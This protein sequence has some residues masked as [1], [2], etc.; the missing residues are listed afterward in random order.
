MIVQILRCG[1]NWWAKHS[2]DPSDPLCF[3]RNSAYFNSTGLMFGRRLRHLFLY[4]GRIRF[5]RTSG[6]DPEFVER[7]SGKT[8]HSPGPVSYNGSKSLLFDLPAKGQQPDA[9]LATLNERD[10]GAIDF[11]DKSWRSTGVDV[12]A[13]SRF[14][15]RYEAML[16][17]RTNAWVCTSLGFWQVSSNS[18]QLTISEAES[19]DTE[20]G[21]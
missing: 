12:I 11:Q 5:N 19:C 16:L 1:V 21:M 2:K 18:H 7:I 4:R 8:F 3:S 10:H 14:R 6:F 15:E 9:Y 20:K 17:M 13:V